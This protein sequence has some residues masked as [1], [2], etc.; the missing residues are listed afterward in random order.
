MYTYYLVRHEFTSIL[1]YILSFF[2]SLL[3]LL[4]SRELPT[5]A[6]ALR[7]KTHIDQLVILSTYKHACMQLPEPIYIYICSVV[8]SHIGKTTATNGISA[9][10]RSLVHPYIHT[11][12]IAHLSFLLSFLSYLSTYNLV[13]MMLSSAWLTWGR[14]CELLYVIV[15]IENKLIINMLYAVPV[16]LHFGWTN[17]NDEYCPCVC[18]WPRRYAVFM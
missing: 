1:T 9:T 15:I 12:Q 10:A 4:L 17:S 16:P 5:L 7:A 2:F 3:L 6:A 18:L 14:R 13:F 8:S 11:L